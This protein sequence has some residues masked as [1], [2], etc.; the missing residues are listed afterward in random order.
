MEEDVV[1]AVDAA[2]D[3]ADGAGVGRPSVAFEQRGQRQRDGVERG[4]STAFEV[5]GVRVIG[6]ERVR[7]G[8]VGVDTALERPDRQPDVDRV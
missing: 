1:L 8:G 7:L 4:H 6:R 3:A 5:H 2:A